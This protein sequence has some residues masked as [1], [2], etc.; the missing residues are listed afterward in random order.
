MQADPLAELNQCIFNSSNR[1]V[2][3]M[4]DIGSSYLTRCKPHIVFHHHVSSG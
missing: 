3:N 2:V 1:F 4:V